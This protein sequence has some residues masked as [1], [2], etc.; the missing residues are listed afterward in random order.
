MAPSSPREADYRF[1]P[2]ASCRPPGIFGTGNAREQFWPIE[3][4]AE[5]VGNEGGGRFRAG[6][7]ATRQLVTGSRFISSANQI[8]REPWQEKI[9]GQNCIRTY[10]TGRSHSV[11]CAVRIEP[12]RTLLNTQCDLSQLAKS[13]RHCL[14]SRVFHISQ[15]ER[16]PGLATAPYP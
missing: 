15:S 12:L 3:K 7:F 14:Q 9:A 4:E 16:P 1:K 10:F 11:N 2:Q 5:G 8:N 6:K 13:R